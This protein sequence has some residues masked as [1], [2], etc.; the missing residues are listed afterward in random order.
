MNAMYVYTDAQVKEFWRLGNY[1]DLLPLSIMEALDFLVTRNL[2]NDSDLR[3]HCVA[4]FSACTNVTAEEVD[5]MVWWTHAY[6]LCKYDRTLLG[7]ECSEL[8]TF[9]SRRQWVFNTPAHP[10]ETFLCTRLA[11]VGINPYDVY[12][13]VYP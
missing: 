6:V 2:F 9:Q 8:E 7:P 1:D 11:T 12:C 10:F 5:D 4:T 3:K 13:T